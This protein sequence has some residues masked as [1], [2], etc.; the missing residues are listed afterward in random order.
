MKTIHALATAICLASALNV[1]AQADLLAGKPI[2]TLGEAKTWTSSNGGTYTFVTAD[3]E[4]LVAT[5]TNTSNV[6][7]FPETGGGWDTDANHQIGIQGFYVDMEA[8]KSVGTVSTTWEG[9]AANDYDIYLTDTEPT[10]DILNTTPVYSAQNLGQ[11]QAN[12]AVMPAGAKGRYLVFQV[13]RPTNWGWGVKIRSI[14]ALAPV[15]AEMTVF[16]ATPAIVQAGV[17]TPMHFEV[18]DQLGLDIAIEDVTISVSD[19]A[20]YADGKLT[21]NSGNEAVITA[22]YEGVSLSSSVYVA[23]APALPVATD[24]K[25][26][27]YSNTVTD[28]NGDVIWTVAYNGGAVNNGEMTFA[29][30]EVVWSFGNV[31]CVFFANSNVNGSWDGHVYPMQDGYRN[32]ELSV[33]ASKDAQGQIVF[34]GSTP[35][36]DFS[37]TGGQWN[38]LSINVAD[39]EQLNNL[40]IRFNEANMCDVLLANIY[41]TPSYV[42]GDEE[43]PVLSEISLVEKSTSSVT[44][45][46]S[47]TDNASA[48]VYYTVSDGTNNYSLSGA[49]GETV[50]CTVGN[51][52]PETEYTFTVT[53]SD[54]KNIAE[55]TIT[56]TT[57]ALAQMGDAPTPTDSDDKVVALFST[58]YGATTVPQFDSWGSSAQAGTLTVNGK[59]ILY[60]SNYQGQWGGLVNL[61][62]GFQSQNINNNISLHIDIY[63]FENDG[64]LTIAPVWAGATD[65][66]GM[67]TVIAKVDTPNKTVEV[68]AN[69]WNSI[70]VPLTDF[71]YPTYGSIITQFAMTNSTVPAFA[72]DNLYVYG[73]DALTGVESVEAT[74]AKVVNVYNM[75]GRLMR[76]GVNAADATRE[77]P[78]G[79][80]IVG[81]LKVLVK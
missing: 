28:N 23:T 10:L 44:L 5:P 27:I 13:T 39:K 26:A 77:L 59:E 25:A 9:A 71:A 32:L 17:E 36:V 24:I 53:A 19:N 6:F 8:S 42:E 68:K 65:A 16:N 49:S 45:S 52:D 54:G 4:K 63:G 72:V 74:A 21:V 58:H 70:D 47:A 15:K 51:L 33:F 75:Q 60:F 80:Y 48:T 20:T 22:T 41:F 76:A 37:L 18:K 2:H 67:E 57:E 34:E 3:L 55:K 1:A 79:I 50:S 69:Q 29:D 11:Y 30:G 43:A 61:D 64:T 78:A 14:S 46:F 31:R 35:S 73:D 12:T 81:N 62:W 7:L 40:S 66:V 38:Q 56:V